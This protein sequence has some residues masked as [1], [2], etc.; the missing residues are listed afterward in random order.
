MALLARLDKSGQKL[1]TVL[2]RLSEQ[3]SNAVACTPLNQV[4]LGLK[5]LPCDVYHI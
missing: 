2:Q 1:A 4:L 3:A 5:P